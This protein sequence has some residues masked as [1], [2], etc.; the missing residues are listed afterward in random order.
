MLLAAPCHAATT[1]SRPLILSWCLTLIY[2]DHNKITH[3]PMCMVTLICLLSKK[4]HNLMGKK[5]TWYCYQKRKL[6]HGMCSDAH[7]FLQ[8]HV[9]T[10][11]HLLVATPLARSPPRCPI[12]HACCCLPG[13]TT[14][15]LNSGCR[16]WDPCWHACMHPC[17]HVFLDVYI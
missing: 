7:S 5:G 4:L 9:Q 14:R 3:I 16:A 10:R 12:T 1:I 15:A 8:Q 13:R 17:M 6:E 2:S 11:G